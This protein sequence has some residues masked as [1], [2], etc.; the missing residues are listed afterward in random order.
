MDQVAATAEVLA[1]AKEAQV[2]KGASATAKATGKPAPKAAS[3]VPDDDD[4][5]G[6]EDAPSGGDTPA[7]PAQPAPAGSA[8]PNLFG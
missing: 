2:K 1:A 4:V 8:S 3:T 7:S 5:E 6:G